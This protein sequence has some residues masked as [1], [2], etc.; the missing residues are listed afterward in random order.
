MIN[1]LESIV[2]PFRPEQVRLNRRPRRGSDRFKAHFH[3]SPYS[4]MLQFFLHLGLL[5]LIQFW[6][7]RPPEAKTPTRRNKWESYT[8]QRG[9]ERA[10][11][12]FANPWRWNLLPFLAAASDETRKERRCW[13][14]Q[15]GR[16][17]GTVSVLQ[18]RQL[19]PSHL[20]R[21]CLCVV[22]VETSG[23]AVGAGSFSQREKWRKSSFRVFGI[24]TPVQN[25]F[26]QKRKK[27]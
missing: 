3:V 27:T 6:L 4:F 8:E 9:P 12:W 16:I 21:V 14:W 13:S 2:Q 20:T 24:W 19:T 17:K 25:T 10:N 1:S 5:L 22:R 11:M 23:A 18:Y 7:L 15:L 26:T